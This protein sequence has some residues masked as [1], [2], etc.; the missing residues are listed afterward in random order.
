MTD[1]EAFTDRYMAVWHQ[2]DRAERLAQ[3]ADLWVEDGLHFSTSH[4]ARGYAE[5]ETRIV[6]AYDKFVAEGGYVFRR[7]GVVDGHHGVIR[8]TWAMTPAAGGPIEAMGTDVFVLAPDGR[9]QVDYQFTDPT[10]A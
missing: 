5:L 2:P 1:L 7:H 3:I 9:I 10:P 6:G 4:A 8:F